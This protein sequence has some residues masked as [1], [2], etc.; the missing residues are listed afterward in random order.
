MVDAMVLS[1]LRLALVPLNA[2]GPSRSRL[3]LRRLILRLQTHTVYA[4]R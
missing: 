1:L 4:D 3:A 2:A